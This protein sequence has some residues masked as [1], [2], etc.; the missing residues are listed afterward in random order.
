MPPSSSEKQRL[1]KLI[2]KLGKLHRKDKV[3]TKPKYSYDKKKHDDYVVYVKYEE[4]EA[5]EQ[6]DDDD[7]D[8]EYGNNVI[9]Y[10]NA[11]PD[12]VY[13][14]G[15]S[16]EAPSEQPYL[17]DKADLKHFKPYIKNAIFLK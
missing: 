4:E 16:Y 12:D 5:E 6:D 3:K 17:F 2:H 11:Y 7:E 14:S 15:S 9:S 10:S 13:E 1:E 8:G